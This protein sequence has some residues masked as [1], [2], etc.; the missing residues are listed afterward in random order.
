MRKHIFISAVAV[1]GLAGLA[2]PA[3]ADAKDGGHVRMVRLQDRCDPASFNAAIGPGT[4]APHNGQ[5]INFADFVA[6]LNMQTHQGSPKWNI[7]PDMIELRMGDSISASV[8]GGEFHTFT[9]V[10]DFGPGCV[11]LLNGLLGLSGPPAASCALLA[12]TGTAPGAPPVMVS[13][14]APGMHKFMCL[15]HPWMQAEVMVR[16]GDDD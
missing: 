10:K 4:C 12:T 6:A 13:G 16:A 1:V 3:S 9:E 15:I 8:R 7:H 2:I 14:L 5:L 11:A